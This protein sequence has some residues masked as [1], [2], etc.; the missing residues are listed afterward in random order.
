M[1]FRLVLCFT[2]ASSTH[3]LAVPSLFSF[4]SIALFSSQ[5]R[6]GVSR[7]LGFVGF[8]TVAEAA[9]AQKYF[10]RTFIDAVRISVEVSQAH[11]IVLTFT[12]SSVLLMAVHIW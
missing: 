6:E 9:A 2:V 8:K 10:D 3:T 5:P 7:Q 4:S 1:P 12:L 11:F